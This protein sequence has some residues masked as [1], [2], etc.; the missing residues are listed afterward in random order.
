MGLLRLVGSL[1]LQVSFAK[2]PYKRDNNLQKRPII[3]KS[4]L[5]IATPYIHEDKNRWWCL[6]KYKSK[7]VGKIK[8]RQ[9]ICT[10]A[11]KI[12]TYAQAAS[13]AYAKDSCEKMTQRHLDAK[14]HLHTIYIQTYVIYTRTFMQIHMD[15]Q[16]NAG[17]SCKKM[18]PGHIDAKKHMHT[19]HM[20][21][22]V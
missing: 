1:Q 3:L 22:L 17:A 14:T 13:V 4:L 12:F 9:Q 5:T 8:K 20:K 7:F 6:V 2:E 21:I 10:Y 18:T 11:K 15:V 16:K 19:K